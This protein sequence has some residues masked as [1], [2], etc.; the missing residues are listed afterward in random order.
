MPTQTN[1]STNKPE[2]VIVLNNVKK[3]FGPMTVFEDISLHVNKNEVVSVL[4][5]SGSGKS[6][7][8]NIIAG[9]YGVDEGIVKVKG[10]IGYMQQKDLLLPWKTV[11]DNIALPLKIKKVAKEDINMKIQKYLP[12]VGLQGYENKYPYQL[13]GGMRQRASFMRTLMTAEDIML[14]DEAFGSLDSVT[15]GQMQKWL[16]E[17]KDILGNTVLFIT[18]DIDEAIYLSDR[19]Y[20]LSKIPAKIQ[21][22][23]V[24]DF[25]KDDKDKRLLSHKLLELKS[26]ILKLL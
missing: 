16:L 20:V 5:S 6:T 12:V 17:M 14:F 24:V 26:E 9:L 3:T 10:S 21:K 23:I 1:S 8:F 13:S 11:Y 18:H 2:E 7:L 22:E 15:R 19:I 25:H 4:G